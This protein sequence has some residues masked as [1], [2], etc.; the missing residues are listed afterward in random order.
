LWETVFAEEHGR[1]LTAAQAFES[2]RS[3]HIIFNYIVVSERR[4]SR[5]QSPSREAVF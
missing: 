4:D 1:K 3:C 5:R 2:W